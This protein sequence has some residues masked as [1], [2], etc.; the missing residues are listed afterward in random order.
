MPDPGR[1]AALAAPRAIS[2]KECLES[3][4]F[5]YGRS[6]GKQAEDVGSNLK[7]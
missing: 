3:V 7:R 1:G 2:G 5:I 4:P 6:I